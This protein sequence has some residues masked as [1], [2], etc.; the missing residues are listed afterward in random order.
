[1]FPP[2]FVLMFFPECSTADVWQKHEKFVFCETWSANCYHNN[3]NILPTSH[4]GEQ[5]TEA[6]KA[7]LDEV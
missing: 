6:A 2:V 4:L 3:N 5:L 1:M 7:R